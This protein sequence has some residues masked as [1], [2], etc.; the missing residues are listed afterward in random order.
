[1]FENY[2]N[3]AGSKTVNHIT[4]YTIQFENYVNY[5][6]SKTANPNQAY[7]YTFENYVNYA[8]SKTNMCE[9]NIRFSLRTM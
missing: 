7:T 4:I 5:A 2:V 1:M 3:Y 8:G 6:G 9:C